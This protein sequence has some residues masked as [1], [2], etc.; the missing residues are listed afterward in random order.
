MKIEDIQYHQKNTFKSLKDLNIS[1]SDFLNSTSTLGISES[2][3]LD[4]DKDIYLNKDYN[5]SS[6]NS[7]LLYK[8]STY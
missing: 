6:V 3:I 2:D 7:Y 8:L 1:M 4:S 5:P